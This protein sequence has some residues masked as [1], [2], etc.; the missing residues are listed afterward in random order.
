MRTMLSLIMKELISFLR[1]WGLVAVVLYSFTFD[2]YIAGKGI[3]MQ[4]KNVAV[5]YV[6]DSGGGLSQKILSRLHRPEFQ[7]PVRFLSQKALSDAIF[8]REIMVGLVFD[9]DFAKRYRATGHTQ[10]N[11]LLDSIAATQS[12]QA[13]SYLQNIL[14]DY[15]KTDL[16]VDLA[17]HKLFNQN[18]TTSWFMALAE[19]LSI[20]T[21]L[22]VILTAAVFVREKENG[23]WDIMLLMPI[24]P[25]LIILAKSFSQVLI[26]MAGVV[27]ATGI[28]L[29]GAFDVPI[30]GSIWVFFLLSF[31]Y[32]FTSAGIGL[33]V[34]AVS[35]TMLEVAMVA[36]LIMMPLIFLSGAWTPIH[37]MHPLLQ[38]LSLISP[39]RYYI[40][41]SES[42]FFRGTAVTDL[43]PYFLGV[44][45]LGLLLYLYGF[46]KIGKL[47]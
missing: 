47:F 12:F 5:G 19:M 7:P 4:A 45:I 15:S 20:S 16:P 8:N 43:W 17:V 26:I 9:Q 44:T 28:V 29:F 35:R 46:R 10:L 39:L 36:I 42:I 24:D 30:N 27:I 23:T 33:F 3:E 32:A 38:K 1:S 25:K 14:L 18:A 22:G 31:L 41:G 2:I 21:L 13:L 11:I 34:A 40:E 37:A 6:D